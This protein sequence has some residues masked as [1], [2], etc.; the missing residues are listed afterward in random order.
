MQEREF[1]LRAKE[2]KIKADA[3]KFKTIQENKKQ[4]KQEEL[5]RIDLERELDKRDKNGRFM[6]IKQV[7]N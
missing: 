6:Q 3:E 5:F 1:Q 4:E 7:S 2:Q